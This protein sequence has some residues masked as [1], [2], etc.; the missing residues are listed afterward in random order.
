MELNGEYIEKLKEKDEEALRML[1]REYKIPLYNYIYR[2]VYNREDAED[3]LQETFLKIFRNI[4]K[5]DFRKN[6]KSFIFKVAKNSCIDFF[7]KKKNALPFFDEV[8][9]KPDNFYERIKLKGRLE[10]ALSV[11][12]KEDREIIILKYIENFKIREISEM[13]E[14][15]ENTV[16]IRIFRALKKMRKHFEGGEE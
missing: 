7:R 4:K 5:I 13:L 12:K 3:I 1:V 2:M 15:P 8:Y 10:K 9:E 14:I 6:F 16:K 11:L